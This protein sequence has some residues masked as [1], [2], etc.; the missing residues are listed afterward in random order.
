MIFV[1][2]PGTG[3]LYARN[4]QSERENDAAL[5]AAKERRDIKSLEPSCCEHRGEHEGGPW[6]SPSALQ[7]LARIAVCRALRSSRP[8][9]RSDARAY[10]YLSFG[11]TVAIGNFSATQSSSAG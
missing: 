5:P 1:E 8:W 2:V 7:R 11:I 6:H 4:A 10:D 9:D 3:G